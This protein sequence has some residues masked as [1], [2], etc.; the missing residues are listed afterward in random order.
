M[1]SEPPTGAF[2][3]GAGALVVV[4]LLA[5]VHVAKPVLLPIV[6]AAV[7]TMLLL[8]LARGL[9]GLG[10][11]RA[12][13]AALL[14]AAFV[15]G[16]GTLA[17]V[18][19]E[20]VMEWMERAPTSL[21]GLRDELADLKGPVEQVA[22]AADQVEEMTATGQET[23]GT[24]VR[25]TDR[26]P[27]SEAVLGSTWR[28][29]TLTGLT[30]I[31]VLFFLVY[32]RV[33]LAKLVA[34]MPDAESRRR[35]LAAADSVH[36][37][38]GRFLVWKAVINA[39]LGVAVALSLWALGYSNPVLWGV[40]AAI[41]NI[42]PYLGAVVGIG[43][44]TLVGLLTQDGLQ[45]ALM[46]AGAYALLTSLEG[47]LLTPAILGTR[48]SLDPISIL[49]GV[50]VAGFVWGGAGVLLSVPLLVCTKVAAEYHPR[51]RVLALMLG[52]GDSALRLLGRARCAAVVTP[53][54]APARD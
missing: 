15:A 48:L 37:R 6:L 11:P 49:V 27:L 25:V 51:G 13:A 20:P 35:A 36:T 8:P 9:E 42:V 54:T 47:M 29:M 12:V 53:T 31:L 52:R 40:M 10:L 30:T 41:L 45:P 38:L 1:N 24:E 14:V 7:L 18:L 17:V 2:R 5:V 46:G 39:G 3:L 32:R 43:I 50:L 28:V 34:L 33:V 26:Q 21:A 44:I 22:R 19:R 16:V 4:L 23:A